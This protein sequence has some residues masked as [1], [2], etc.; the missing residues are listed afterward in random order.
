MRGVRGHCVMI[1]MEVGT[2]PTLYPHPNIFTT[3]RNVIITKNPYVYGVSGPVR[4]LETSLC[5][6]IM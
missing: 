1:Y 3:L 6:K 5:P 2:H 4:I